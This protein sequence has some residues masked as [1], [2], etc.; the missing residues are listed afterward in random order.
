MEFASDIA[1]G[2]PLAH[3]ATKRMVRS[4]LDEGVRGADGHVGDIAAALFATEDLQGAVQTFLDEGPGK[5]TFE[6]R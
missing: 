3:A 1:A 6:G 5:A 2:P 4:F